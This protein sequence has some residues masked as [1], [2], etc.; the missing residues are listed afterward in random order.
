MAAI[1]ARLR[2]AGHQYFLKRDLLK[3]GVLY[4]CNG[5]LRLRYKSSVFV[6]SHCRRP[7]WGGVRVFPASVLCTRACRDPENIPASCRI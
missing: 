2:L 1:L 5:L 7:Q 4:R 3:G 6:V